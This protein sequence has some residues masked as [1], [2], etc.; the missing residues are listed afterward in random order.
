MQTLRMNRK[1]M[2]VKGKRMAVNKKWMAVKGE[3]MVVY[4]WKMIA[5]QMLRHVPPFFVYAPSCYTPVS[6]FKSCKNWFLL[7]STNLLLYT[8]AHIF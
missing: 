1:W 6:V 8:E 3:W 7:C 5:H 2:A 4:M